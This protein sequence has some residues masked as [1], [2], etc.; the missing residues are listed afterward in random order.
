MLSCRDRFHQNWLNFRSC[1]QLK[2][3]DILPTMLHRIWNPLIR[4]KHESFVI[5]S[6]STLLKRLWK[7]LNHFDCVCRRKQ[8][9]RRI[10]MK[11]NKKLNLEKREETF[12]NIF[13]IKTKLRLTIC[14]KNAGFLL[15]WRQLIDEIIVM[16]PLT[17]RFLPHWK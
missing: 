4:L 9:T 17:P 15:E 13:M 16:S 11:R 6:F 2:C 12:R 10:M 8:G 1:V 3:T 7:L 14:G 5:V